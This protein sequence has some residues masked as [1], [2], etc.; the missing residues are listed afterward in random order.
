MSAPNNAN[1]LFKEIL[2]L[3]ASLKKQHV[4]ISHLTTSLRQ[5]EDE[6]RSLRAQQAN[7]VQTKKCDDNI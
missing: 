2:E 1:D 3:R 4:T 7:K 5:S 6:V